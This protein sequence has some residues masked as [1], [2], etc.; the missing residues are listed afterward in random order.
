MQKNKIFKMAASE[1]SLVLAKDQGLLEVRSI[2][3]AKTTG[4]HQ[5]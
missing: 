1:S 4:I 2:D 3:T 5:Q